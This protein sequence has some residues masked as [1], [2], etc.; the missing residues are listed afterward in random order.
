MTEP[1]FCTEC[2]GITQCEE[3]CECSDCLD[4]HDQ[5]CNC[6]GCIERRVEYAEGERECF[7]Y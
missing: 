6:E 7:D 4:S 1:D 3:E 2:N 5:P